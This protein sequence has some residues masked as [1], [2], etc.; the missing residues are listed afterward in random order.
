MTEW[1]RFDAC[2]RTVRV[3]LNLGVFNVVETVKIELAF[4]KGLTL[5]MSGLRLRL[6][7][8]DPLNGGVMI[9]DS[10]T[11]PENPFTLT[12]PSVVETLDPG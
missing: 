11:F 10:L 9:A 8:W 6:T 1:L 4:P 12:R 7:V 3:K 2:P 5:T